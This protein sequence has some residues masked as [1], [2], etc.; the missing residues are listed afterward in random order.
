MAIYKKAVEKDRDRRNEVYYEFGR[1][2]IQVLNWK[3]DD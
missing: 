3:R 1:I 2:H